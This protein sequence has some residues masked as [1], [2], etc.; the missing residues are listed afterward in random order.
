MRKL[1]FV[2]AKLKGWNKDSFGELNERK[3]SILNEI[4]NIAAVEQEG[5]LT[6]ELSA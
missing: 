2:K 1:Q 4:T 6:F 5:V 3:K